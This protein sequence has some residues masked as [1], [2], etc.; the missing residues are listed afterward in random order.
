MQSS[1]NSSIK[2]FMVLLFQASPYMWS[3]HFPIPEASLFISS[4][5][6]LDL[7]YSAWVTLLIPYLTWKQEMEGQ[8]DEEGKIKSNGNCQLERKVLIP[9]FWPWAPAVTSAAI[10]TGLLDNRAW[11]MEKRKNDKIFILNLAVIFPFPWTRS[12]R[13]LLE[14]SVSDCPTIRF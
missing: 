11:E 4:S 14:L 2:N 8:R 12:S 5:R 13:H 6:T 10:T 9:Q 7:W 3:Q 1:R